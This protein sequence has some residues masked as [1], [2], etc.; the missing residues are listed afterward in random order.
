[1]TTTIKTAISIPKSLFEKAESLAQELNISRSHLF[2]LAIETYIKNHQNQILL[3]E[4]NRAY[5]DEPEP[6]E[7]ILISRMRSQHRKLVENEW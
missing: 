1:M 5:T 7:K 6:G 4:I 3:D 2:G